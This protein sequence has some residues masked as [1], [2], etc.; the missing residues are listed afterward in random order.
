MADDRTNA[1]DSPSAANNAASGEPI[2]LNAAGAETLTVPHGPML[3]NANFVRSGSELQ[4]TGQAGEQVMVQN[5]FGTEMAPV[6]M[7]EGGGKIMPDVAESLAGPDILGGGEGDAT[8]LGQSDQPIGTVDT[9]EGGVFAV[10]ADGTRVELN[11]GDPVFQGDVLETDDEGAVSLTFVDNTEFALDEGARMVLDEMVFDAQTG[12]GSSTFTVV[13][14]VFTFVSGQ[15]AKSGSDAMTVNTP[16]ATIGIRGTKVAIKAGSEDEDTVITLLQEDSGHIGEIAVTNDA[17]TQVMN[18]ANQTTFIQSATIAPTAP[19]ILPSEQLRSIFTEGASDTRGLWRYEEGDENR[20]D[21]ATL[22]ETIEDAKDAAAEE[23]ADEESVENA[24]AAAELAFE[25][26]LAEGED[27]EEA[28]EQA[29][30]AFQNALIDDNAAD[31]LIETAAGGDDFGGPLGDD[32][33]TESVFDYDPS[34]GFGGANAGP[35]TA[36]GA[37]FGGPDGDFPD[38][39]S[40]APID[41]VIRG[42]DDADT[43]T[44]TE[45]ADEIVAGGGAD[46]VNALGGDDTVDAGTGNDT[47]YGGAGDD[48]ID[49]GAGDDILYGDGDDDTI[50]GG[51]GND[52][53]FGNAG[54]DELRGD[55]DDDVISGGAG[56]DEIEGGDGDDIAF[57]GAGSD[58]IDM[59]DGDDFIGTSDDDGSD[60]NYDGGAGN[61][62]VSFAAD[63]EG[64]TVNLDEDDNDEFAIDANTARGDDTGED[65]IEGIENVT[66]GS[67]DD[68]IIG[69][70][71]EA[72]VIDAGAG[73]DLV[74]GGEDDDLVGGAG[75]DTLRISMTR[76]EFEGADFQAEVAAYRADPSTPFHFDSINMDVESFEQLQ[77]EV[78]G[79]IIVAE[80]PT[81]EVGDVFG[82][83]D[84][85]ILLGVGA[86]L[87]DTDG[88]E[89]LEV[90]IGGLPEGSTLHYIDGN[91]V[92][93]SI[94]I[95]EGE[96]SV[97]ISGETQAVL[98]T[99]AVTPP[100]GDSAD[101]AIEVTAT[102]IELDGS[103]SSVSDSFSVIVNGIPAALPETVSGD[104]DAGTLT[105][106]L[107]D[108]I[109]GDGTI[110]PDS[111]DLAFSIDGVT[112]N[113][114]G[115]YVVISPE[116]T[117]TLHADGSYEF[118]IDSSLQGL[119]D[120]ESAVAQFTFTATDNGQPI[121]S[122]SNTLTV[123]VTGSNDGPV[124]EVALI[125]GTEDSSVLTGNLEA[126][127]LDGEALT[128]GIQGSTP[129]ANGVTTVDVEGTVDGSTVTIGQLVVQ[130][131]GSYAFTPD[132]D[133][134]QGMNVGDAVTANLAF[135]A[136]DGTETT[137]AVLEITLTGTDDGLVALAETVEGGEDDGTLTGNLEATDADS[138]SLTFSLAAGEDGEGQYGSLTVNAD[139]SYSFDIAEAAQALDDGETVIETFTY[140]VTSDDETTTETVTVT[141]TGSNDGPVATAETV[142]GGEDAGTL[143]GNLDATDVD[144]DDLTFS[145]QS[146]GEGQYGTLTVDPD[147]SYSFDL[148][149]AAQGLDDG[150]SAVETFTYQVTDGDVTTTETV[151]VTITGSNDG[152]VASA[153]TV[154]GGE[155]AGTLTGNLDATDIDGDDLTF[156]LQGDG[157]GQFGNLTVNPDGSYSF[158]IADAA[159]GLDD[160]E[161]AVETFTYEVTDGDVT[162]TETVTVTITGSNDGPV[163]SAETVAGGEDAGTLTGNLDATDI[164]GDDLTFSL[165]GD[166]EGQYGNL[167]VNP[168]GS[169][170][171]DIAEAAQ[172][173]DDGESA[174]ET[175]TYEVTD[176]DVT[177]TETVSVTITGSNDGPVASAETVAGGE[178]AG[179]LTGNLDA[180][181]IDGD[182]LTFSLQGDGEGQ[183]GNLTVN[184]NGSYSFAIAAAA[185]ALDD[186][187]SAVETFTYEVTDGDVTTTETVTV[188]ITGSNDGPVAS[189][190]TVAGSED[191]GT[192][193]GNLDATD[194]DGDDLTFS[195]QG[196]GEGQYGNLT[197]NADGSYSF[198][199]AEAAQGL[200]DG[201]SAVET[202]T[203]EVTDGD[204]TTT[205]TIQVTVT[206]S[207]DA[208][209]AEAETVSGQADDAQLTGNL[210]ATDV[211]GDDL[212]FSLQGDGEGQ[213]G[214]LTVNPDGSYT[215]DIGDAAQNLANGESV[216]ETFTYEVTDG[217]VTTTQ[218]I[219][220][221]VTGS[222]NAPVATPEFVSGHEDDGVIPGNSG[223]GET[224]VTA[225]FE[226]ESAG[227]RNIIGSYKV[228]AD[229]K[230]TDVQF[231]WTNA[232][233]Q[234]S[235]GTMQS[236]DQSTIETGEN[237]EFGLFIVADGY[238][239]NGGLANFD[240][241]N[242]SLEF[243]NAD[244]TP[245]DIDSVYPQLF[246]VDQGGQAVPV[247][248]PVYHSAFGNLNQDGIV[249]TTL[250]TDDD[251]NVTVGW[252][253][254][255]HGGDNDYED[256]VM[257]LNLGESGGVLIDP[258]YSGG[259]DNETLIGQLDATDADGDDLT[260]DLAD[261]EDGVGEYGT[262]VVNPDGTYA[263][264]L[265]ANAQTLDDGE[266]GV[267]TFTW[268]V[269][270]GASVTTESITITIAGSN[271]GPVATAETVG[272]GEDAGTLTGN[273]D[274]TDVEGD[275][276]TF[277]LQGDGEGQYGTLTVNP[278]GSYS[279]DID[280][281][282][283]GLDDGESAVE[284]FTYEVT[285]GDVTTTETVTVTI[286]GSNDGP[287]ASAE[288]V[289]GGEDAGTLTGNLDA[290][291]L[292]GDNLTFSLQGNGEGQYGNLTVNANGSYSFAI[293][294]AAQALDD[295]E[296]AVETFTYEVTDGDVTTT[297]TITVT[298]QGSN[299]GPVAAAEAISGGEDAGTLTGNLEATDIEGDDLTFSLQGDG[300][301]QYGDLTVNADGSYS[302][303]IGSA[304]QGLDDGESAVETFTYEVTDGD[305]TSTNTVTV[306]IT[307]SNDG[308]VAQAE[309][310]S[311]SEDAG[312]LTGNLDAFDVDGDDLTFSLQGSGEGTYGTLSVNA[313]GSYSF[314][315]GDAAQ[316]LEEGES[317]VET[318]TYEVTDGDETAT[319]SVS[320]T[321][322]GA[323]EGNFIVGTECHDYLVGTSGADNISGLG[324]N[325]W[326]WAGGGDDIVDGGDGH[327]SI[328]GG[329]GND[330]IDGGDG[331]DGIWGGTGDDTL[332]GGAGND[333]LTGQD[334]NDTLYGGDGN[335]KLYGGDGND[336][337]NGGAGDDRIKG[338]SGD[339]VIEGGFGEDEIDGG[340][341]DDIIYGDTASYDG[342][343]Y[344]AVVNEH[345]PVAFWRLDDTNGTTATDETG[346]HDGTYE[347]G[348][349]IGEAGAV[350][351][352]A[353]AAVFDGHNDHVEVPHDDAFEA[354]SG[355]VMMW[356]RPDDLGGD[357]GLF[358]K[359]SK[360]YDDGGHLHIELDGSK[361][362]VRLQGR[363]NENEDFSS[364][365]VESPSGTAQEGQ[366]MQVAFTWGATGMA[367]YV[368]GTLVD[369][370]SFTGGIEDN[371]EPIVMGASQTHSGDQS[372]SG[373][374]EFFE[375]AMDEVAFFDTALSDEAI[376]ETFTAGSWNLGSDDEI[377]AGSGD[378]IVYGG[379]GDDEIEGES[380]NDELHGGAGEDEIEG[381]SGHDT[382]Y[383]DA[384]DDD[385]E[386]GSGDDTIYGGEGDDEIEGDSG[387]DLIVGGLGDDEIDGG[388]GDDIIIGGDGADILDGGSGENIFMYNAASEGG[389]TVIG[390]D[391]DK[392]M[393][394]FDGDDFGGF[395]NYTVQNDGSDF[396]IIGEDGS[397][398]GFDDDSNT[399]FYRSGD[400]AGEGYQT[401]ATV[402][403]DDVTADDIEII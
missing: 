270:D 246:Y 72:N 100:D 242:G 355:T 53:I 358:S 247:N 214:D 195:L 172:G 163:A 121:L 23:G 219:S 103:V 248:G 305:V 156:S 306:T 116:G 365:T 80:P 184:A 178:D 6:L 20:N 160:G 158:D 229:G 42:G 179:T 277:S 360:H 326:I 97:V 254:L 353:G 293:A 296:S 190:E 325:D 400:D 143:T 381:G 324:G 329:S 70:T 69:Q 233:M 175:F 54:D 166:G 127:D 188:T 56:D 362:K 300:E 202:F 376:A 18:Q 287:V 109:G 47:V 241:E 320:V 212:T 256:V 25:L 140:E 104:E 373:L 125:E 27:E 289:S 123:T 346:N 164:D 359:D 76:E 294:A 224:T 128:F 402:S 337:L 31:S 250:E 258:G 145:L 134:L 183:Y 368:N 200:D 350:G 262:L 313:N 253:D 62:T 177:T 192:L 206:G 36:G 144:G 170:S 393:F 371:Q 132:N 271:D 68:V 194:V 382:I 280:D 131:D 255:P 59:G 387:D 238:S 372:S 228:D 37:T 88:A 201:E 147:G 19:A 234:G 217:D 63:T 106:N 182:D 44:G 159:Q 118:A 316:G 71:G 133:A 364:H 344:S 213:Y 67:G 351:D 398:I 96:G 119:D 401:I 284:T 369:S 151:T 10:R 161:S 307:G 301:G 335:D 345:G 240:L 274:A 222:N 366:W 230:I 207:N 4:L 397:E 12:E 396:K 392:D 383:G 260:F 191:A 239:Q 352:S 173:L 129:D 252:E 98:D 263:F 149:E 403:G 21:G 105:G 51:A 8:L 302:F 189:A 391:S 78:D 73:D 33:G 187:E 43:L 137:A 203:Y 26:A 122:D 17:G 46:I 377:E 48:T 205:Q 363:E 375:G 340:S 235:G 341:G 83:E 198:A 278:D 45:G 264:T 303:D 38:G 181:D 180:T 347:G 290:T 279:F 332:T 304:A 171:F 244:G 330:I 311:G 268:Q 157:A 112:P 273:L 32:G 3:L 309:A 399:L 15:V 321:I 117:L 16:V 275:D 95:T 267:E 312:T 91:G 237:G 167:T 367:L 232:S 394:Q 64:V 35:G 29:A 94:E 120:G 162:T 218:T 283:Q 57:G 126:T 11:E 60:D 55:D 285:D 199:I 141:I 314:A 130:P 310:I 186:G 165:Q 93:Q 286:T 74:I 142:S 79:T 334:G 370:D 107:T 390:F 384:G 265:N 34:A 231:V 58:D 196:N 39:D 148:G 50:S 236:G 226:S 197:V 52:A 331:H 204:V 259:D 5:F 86:S 357:Q 327:D 318:F 153:E 152:P 82:A 272:G 374:R 292:D 114:N 155:D 99:L 87:N 110:D 317:V 115:D 288:T 257:T 61:D 378:D 65:T 269:T 49:G 343:D 75:V 291:D 295:G 328:G 28:L 90:E 249:H 221:T 319:Q 154:A 348:V 176:G 339:D 146:A 308:P 81:L 208:P 169:Y 395:G 85:A 185:Q 220:V 215:Y 225:T 297:E 361:V 379:A 342:P 211:D 101:F 276:L 386:G 124:A 139:G 102:A 210:D 354:E 261:G 136:S 333:Y 299:D 84:T 251:G 243:R 349:A 315:I 298:I 113:A 380:G 92:A 389:D 14:G 266:E 282:A 22:E 41:P 227:Y 193:T 7:T 135:T 336:T 385:I 9:A 24:E 138:E 66:T 13:Q 388:R 281:A 338:G 168:D 2:V 356:I 30:E 323:S 245:A 174:V 223:P 1:P 111:D 209:V 89:S 216:V 150:E 77:I 108:E 40:G 322:T